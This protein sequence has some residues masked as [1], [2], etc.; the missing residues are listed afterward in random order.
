MWY[1]DNEY[2]SYEYTATDLDRNGRL[3]IIFA[4]QQGSGCY[5][6]ANFFEVNESFDG[7]ENVDKKELFAKGG[8]DI[9]KNHTR[10]FKRDGIIY[11]DFDDYARAGGDWSHIANGLL[12]LSEGKLNEA[13][14]ASATIETDDSR[15]EIVSYYDEYAIEIEKEQ[16]D[17]KIKNP[18]FKDI[19]FYEYEDVYF[20]WN[21]SSEE[22]IY[23]KLEESYNVFIGEIKVE[24]P[25]D[26]SMNSD[27][28]F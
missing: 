25:D 26:V 13:I 2:E 19:E 18:S 27:D 17:E 4:S 3:E 15:E 21:D 1:I 8:F 24:N 20:Q 28:G 7:L 16:Y 9:I 23:E 12:W 11:Y 14:Y 6:Y 10:C 5:T 22:N